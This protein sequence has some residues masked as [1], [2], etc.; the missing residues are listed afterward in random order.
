[1]QDLKSRIDMNVS[2]M[3]AHGD[4]IASYCS[5]SAMAF[6]LASDS[7]IALDSAA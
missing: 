3:S 1:M 5:D 4:F 7:P 6:A 2:A